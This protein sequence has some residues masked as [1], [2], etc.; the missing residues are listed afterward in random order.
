[1]TALT[2]ASGRATVPSPDTLFFWVIGTVTF[3]PLL[4]LLPLAFVT[5]DTTGG[6]G[7]LFFYLSM[8]TGVGHVAATGYYYFDPEYRPMLRAEWK[9]TIA[10]LI[11]LPPLFVALYV[12]SPLVTTFAYGAF[13]AWQFYHVTRQNFGFI[14]LAATSTGLADF[15]RVQINHVLN[16]VALGGLAGALC[17]ANAYPTGTDPSALL[18]PPVVLLLKAVAVV[19]YGLASV[20]LVQMIREHP[21]LRTDFRTLAFVVSGWA[22]FLAPAFSGSITGIWACPLN[23]GAQYWAMTA[24]SARNSPW[25]WW[26][27]L[28]LVTVGV[29][30]GF[31]FLIMQYEPYLQKAFLGFF[32]VHFLV[33]ARLWH[34]STS[35]Q[36]EIMR[37]RFGFI[38]ASRNRAAA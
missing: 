28:I 6:L 3:V 10:P 36:R 1:V 8:V 5:G 2:R 20:M 30:V 24:L 18:L 7:R 26:A 38:W 11:A 25:R 32:A 22:F 14:A 15:P 23:H 29:V 27:V 31:A 13:L 17:L 16:L 9:R 35:P 37:G 12:A 19:C 4:V 33:D 34:L 21:E